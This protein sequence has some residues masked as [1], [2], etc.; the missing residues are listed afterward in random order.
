MTGILNISEGSTIALHVTL[1]LSRRREG[2]MTTIR[3]ADI[4]KVSAAHLSKVLQRL[5]KAGIVKPVRGPK[6][7][8]LI[9]RP[10]TEIRLRDVLEAV[11]GP[12]KLQPNPRR[13]AHCGIG[14]CRLGSLLGDIS[15]QV[16]ER[17]EMRLSEV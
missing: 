16:V 7:G 10:L 1:L 8:Y 13:E 5:A 3:A 2:P 6:G 9:N 12:M 11:E 17:F 15:R 14:G 4:L